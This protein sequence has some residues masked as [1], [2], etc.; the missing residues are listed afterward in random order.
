MSAGMWS[1]VEK[2]WKN[3]K[4]FQVSFCK[5][6]SQAIDSKREEFWQIGLIHD[7]YDNTPVIRPKI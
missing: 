1:V 3:N 2:I 4:K 5:I 6:Q 7:L